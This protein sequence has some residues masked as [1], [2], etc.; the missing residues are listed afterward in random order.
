MKNKELS[1]GE[2]RLMKLVWAHP[3]ITS[4]QLVKLCKQELC[5]EKSTVYT[6]I[7]RTA[8]KG[9]LENRDGVIKALVSK[10]EAEKEYGDKLVNE[11][12]SGSL[13]GFIA[14]FMRDRKLTK[15][16]AQKLKELIDSCTE[17]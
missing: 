11:M 7:K 13:P 14:S 16:Q 1:D 15:E 3:D 10:Y 9:F 4:S 17:E 6:V 8:Q 12:F 5:W 2:L